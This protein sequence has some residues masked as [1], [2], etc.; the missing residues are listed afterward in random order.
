MHLRTHRNTFLHWFCVSRMNGT[1]L[2]VLFPGGVCQ[3][4]THIHGY[5]SGSLQRR[6]TM[7]CLRV[8][9]RWTLSLFPVLC[10]Y[11]QPLL[12]DAAGNVNTCLFV[13]HT[14]AETRFLEVA[15][16]GHRVFAPQMLTDPQAVQHYRQRDKRRAFVTW[17]LI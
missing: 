10:Y 1:I 14:S 9:T 4:N 15:F 2:C 11:K 13:H 8:P 12:F 16:V 6:Y 17:R 3:R 5:G 7:V